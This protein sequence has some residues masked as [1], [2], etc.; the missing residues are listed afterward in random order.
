MKFAIIHELSHFL[1]G[2]KGLVF[3]KVSGVPDSEHEY[4]EYNEEA[5]KLA[6][7][8][9]IPHE[10][11]KENLEKSDKEI[12]KRFGV[13]VYAVKERRK[14]IDIEIYMLR[15]GSHS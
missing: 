2:H 12:A 10:Y 13:S 14:E 5:D 3:C 8:L 1:L 6:A 4:K 9:L 7:I 11:M 15:Y